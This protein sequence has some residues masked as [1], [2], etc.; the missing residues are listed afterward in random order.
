M[1][2]IAATG[3]TSFHSLIRCRISNNISSRSTSTGLSL[4]GSFWNIIDC[5]FVRNFGNSSANSFGVNIVAGTNN[6]LTRTIS[7]NNGFT[8]GNQLLGVPSVTTPIAPA[9]SNLAAAQ[10]PWTNMAITS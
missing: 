4:N 8:V 1:N 5:Q 9:T 6:L 2:G 3:S 7:F 10:G